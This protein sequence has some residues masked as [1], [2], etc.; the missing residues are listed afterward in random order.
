MLQKLKLMLNLETIAL[1]HKQA[2]DS[3]ADEG[4]ANPV[5]ANAHV[6]GEGGKV[7]AGSLNAIR[8]AAARGA[9]GT[10]RLLGASQPLLDEAAL[11]AKRLEQVQVL[12][13]TVIQLHALLLKICQ[14]AEVCVC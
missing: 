8:A 7:Q 12:L 3:A 14:N 6:F 10:G 13:S 1:H 2:A 5:N 4:V 11:W 9:Y